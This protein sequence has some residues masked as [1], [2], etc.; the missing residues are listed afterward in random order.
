[1]QHLRSAEADRSPADRQRPNTNARVFYY[2]DCALNE[3]FGHRR[4]VRVQERQLGFWPPL[5]RATEENHR[6]LLLASQ[7]KECAEIG[8]PRYHHPVFHCRARK[9]LSILCG[10]H[11]V[12]A[13]VDSIVPGAAEAVGYH[14]RQCVIDKKLHAVFTNG[15]SR[16]RT[17]SAA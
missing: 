1:M 7:R 8:I 5:G 2:H 10:R 3:C 11:T 17:A 13:H 15:S 14:W 4:E 16:S 6:R 9:D 12:I